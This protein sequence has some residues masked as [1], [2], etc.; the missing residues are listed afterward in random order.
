ME[1]DLLAPNSL[2]AALQG[3]TEAFY[4]VHSM[5]FGQDF[6][7]RDRLCATNFAAAAAEAGVRR[8]IYLGGLTCD[9]EELS[10]HFRSRLEVGDIL[11][12]TGIPVIE[13]RASVIIGSGSLSFELVRSLVERLPV[14]VAPRWVQMQAQPIGIEDVLDYLVEALEMDTDES[15]IYEIGGPDIVSYREIM[16]EYARQRGL[17]RCIIPVPFLTPHLSSLW[18]GLVTPVYARIGRKLIESIRHASVVRRSEARDDFKVQP[19]GFS[20]A[21]ARAIRNEDKSFAETRWVDSIGSSGVPEVT[22]AQRVGNRLVYSRNVEIECSPSR[23]FR[24]IQEIGGRHGWY[25]ADWLW[26]IRAAIDLLLG[27][28]GKRRGRRHPI[29]LRIGDYVDWWRVERFEPDKLLLLFAEMKLPGRAWLQ[30]EVVSNG[31]TCIVCQTAIFEPRGLG[32]LAYWYLVYP[33]HFVV[34]RGMLKGIRLRA[35]GLQES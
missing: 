12:S 7:E 8:I 5:A 21:V 26:S 24:P 29:E 28:V 9:Q 6:E 34:F 14:M 10:S 16:L 15:K 2:K 17:K 23:A 20:E 31:S 11:R 27:G 35:T 32:G 1:G 19:H 4:L 33:L 13:F 22:R 25:A 18:L 30:F 3:V